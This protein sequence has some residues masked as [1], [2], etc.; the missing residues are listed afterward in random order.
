MENLLVEN[1]IFCDLDSI[2]LDL[3]S[4]LFDLSPFEFERAAATAATAADETVGEAADAAAADPFGDVGKPKIEAVV[5]AVVGSLPVTNNDRNNSDG[6]NGAKE[7]FSSLSSL[8][9]PPSTPV[10]TSN[11][12]LHPPPSWNLESLLKSRQQQQQQQHQSS[13]SPSDGVFTPFDRQPPPPNKNIINHQDKNVIQ[14]I[15]DGLKQQQQQQ[16][17]SPSSSSLSSSPSSS[18]VGTTTTHVQQRRPV[19]VVSAIRDEPHNKNS[20]PKFKLE[21]IKEAP[22]S[23]STSS[24]TALPHHQ[25]QQQ[26]QQQQPQQQ[27]TA[28]RTLVPE[29][30]HPIMLHKPLIAKDQKT[31]SLQLLP[32][33]LVNMDGRILS[34]GDLL[35]ASGLHKNLICNL[36]IRPPTTT[37]ATPPGSLTPPISS[38][39]ASSLNFGHFGQY[40]QPQPPESSSSSPSSKTTDTGNDH[41]SHGLVHK[42]LASPINQLIQPWQMHQQQ[43]QQASGSSF[44]SASTINQSKPG[45]DAAAAAAAATLFPANHSAFALR[46]PDPKSKILAEATSLENVF[47]ESFSNKTSSPLVSTSAK[48]GAAAANNWG[49][50]GGLGGGG[51]GEPA[52]N[53]KTSP[54]NSLRSVIKNKIIQAKQQTA[55]K[56]AAPP[57]VVKREVDSAV[58][59]A[60]GI[61]NVESSV[62]PSF[63]AVEDLKS[64]AAEV[65]VFM[66]GERG[67]GDSAAGGPFEGRGA[68]SMPASPVSFNGERE[69]FFDAFVKTDLDEIIPEPLDNDCIICGVAFQTQAAL[70]DH[71]EEHRDHIS[72]IQ[73]GGGGGGQSASLIDSPPY[74]SNSSVVG[75]DD[76][77][78]GTSSGCPSMAD[79]A[80][81]YVNT[82]MPASPASSTSSLDQLL[83]TT[84]SPVRGG[85]NNNNNA[86]NNVASGIGS[87]KKVD[88]G[89]TLASLL[90]SNISPLLT[91]LD[92]AAQ[93]LK[94]GV[95]QNRHHS[96]IYPN[97]RATNQ[98]FGQN[99][100]VGSTVGGNS[101]NN[102]NN[103]IQRNGFVAS[104]F[105]QHQQN[106]GGMTGAKWKKAGLSSG[107]SMSALLGGVGGAG[108]TAAA[109]LVN[110]PPQF[111][112]KIMN[113]DHHHHQ[114]MMVKT[115]VDGIAKVGQKRKLTGMAG[116]GVSKSCPVS[117]TMKDMMMG[118]MAGVHA[119]SEG[120]GGGGQGGGANGA[121]GIAGSDLIAGHQGP[122]TKKCRRVYGLNQKNLW[123]TQCQWKKACARFKPPK[124]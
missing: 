10:I 101:S 104:L 73:S 43:R 56:S 114:K 108:S 117:P 25:Q 103:A 100:L 87:N 78:N 94:S 62:V 17:Q 33:S 30:N 115:T 45:S 97:Q 123:C 23:S 83:V 40:P 19:V 22:S 55:L 63:S 80:E 61:A 113:G 24:S 37:T 18:A 121:G 66:E 107:V 109:S 64:R 8:L 105:Q 46:K 4:D 32:E 35:S 75:S 27:P 98:G 85:A 110:D 9:S 88:S 49:G 42:L 106:G 2:K 79:A 99:L 34:L 77:N 50:G 76:V 93:Q 112:G 53:A 38:A 15:L 81:F 3:D 111:Y 44:D 82:S 54:E 69:S 118:V 74:S 16:Q 52:T 26:Q 29:T 65:G 96:P 89:S 31:G 92:A 51:A 39:A 102:H 57:V 12:T 91:S 47:P 6:A 95:V 119:S 7:A 48:N 120:G 21:M 28:S 70:R 59:A 58:S 71:L 90:V 13:L 86:A 67:G 116:M 20:L 36:D 72:M 11:N 5:D 122:K 1:E 124:Q 60:V 84:A 41:S 68:I 14:Q